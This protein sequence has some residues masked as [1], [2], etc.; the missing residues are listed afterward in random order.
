[1]G[2]GMKTFLVLL[3]LALAIAIGALLI[4]R[5]SDHR[6]DRAVWQRLSAGQPGRPD[7]FRPEMVADLP[8]PARRF[9]LFSIAPGTPLQD[10]VQIEMR[11]RFGMGTRSDPKY[12]DMTAQQVLAAPNGFV[13]KMRAGR[14]MMR[15]S[16]SDTHEWTRFWVLGLLPVARAGGTEDHRRSAFARLVSEA[17]FWSPAALLP[18]PGIEWREIDD[19][20]A[21]VTM[22]HGGLEQT[23]RL[24][25]AENG[26]PTAVW[27]QRWSDAN[28]E[29]TFRL[30][31]FGGTLSEF[32]DF[33]GYRLATHVEAGNFFGTDDYFPFFV[34]DV[35]DI[36]FPAAPE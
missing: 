2:S 24:G 6:A 35:E 23:V 18:G 20:T 9:F 7:V 26:Q 16:G 36:T 3:A 29:K 12:L 27:M 4:W 5:Q 19:K 15:V 32:R 33:A 13:W 30:Q 10:V 14:G 25:V 21:E 31:P 1:M 28:P 8:A 11:G 22:R 34:A 17:L